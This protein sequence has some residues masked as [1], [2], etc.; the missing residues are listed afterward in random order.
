MT[1]ADVAATMKAKGQKMTLT[2]TSV[3]VFNPVT[4]ATTGGVVQ[5]FI[6]YGI[7]KNYTRFNMGG[8][9]ADANSMVI[10]GDK[11]VLLGANVE[12]L[13]TDI[14]TIMGVDWVVISVNETSPQGV[15]LMYSAQIRK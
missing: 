4:G 8:N 7:T 10:S 12:P 5:T 6:V 15:A 3:G 2:R 11:Q 1:P 14:I 13:P 9:F